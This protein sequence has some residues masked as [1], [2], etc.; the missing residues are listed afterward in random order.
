ML[1][2]VF[3]LIF[4]LAGAGTASQFP[5]YVQQYHQR[6]GGAMDELKGYV[7]RFDADA[8]AA[9]LTRDAAL[10]TYLEAPAAFLKKRG[11]A[12][13][14]TIQRFERIETLYQ[15]LDQY[16]QNLRVVAFLKSRENDI[17][18]KTLEAFRPAVPLTLEGAAHAGAGFAFGYMLWLLF[19]GLFKAPVALARKLKNDKAESGTTPDDPSDGPSDGPANGPT[20]PPP[21][22]TA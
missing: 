19:K 8:K 6:L 12:A 1:A 13:K 18:Q 20:T 2:R 9:N 17:A 4:G 22:A 7:A 21:V 3:V 14:D 5:E 15:T 10:Q 16:G 11:Q